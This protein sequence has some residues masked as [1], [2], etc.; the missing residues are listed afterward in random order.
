M[1]SKTYPSNIIIYVAMEKIFGT[2]LPKVLLKYPGEDAVFHCYSFSIPRWIG[3]DPLSTNKNHSTLTM[4]HVQTLD[5]G[6]LT[7]LGTYPNG[8]Q[9][10]AN[11]ELVVARK[12]Y[13]V[14]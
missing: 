12:L 2:I 4:H 5:T 8:S 11:S 13:K 6:I 7:C 3:N 9:F 10:Q 14:T 1:P